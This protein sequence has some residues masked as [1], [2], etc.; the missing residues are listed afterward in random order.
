MEYIYQFN[1]QKLNILDF[2]LF[3]H[4]FLGSVFAIFF[5]V[6]MDLFEARL[7]EQIAITVIASDGCVF[8]ANR[9]P[10]QLFCFLRWLDALHVL[11]LFGRQIRIG[12]FGFFQILQK[13][14]RKPICEHINYYIGD[15]IILLVELF[16]SSS[17]LR[18]RFHHLNEIYFHRLWWDSLSAQPNVFRYF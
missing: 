15:C 11:F 10:W 5:V 16:Y 17:S 1:D 9:T 8:I 2:F 18:L 6:C 3:C 13:K 4:I 14:N 7:A 12:E